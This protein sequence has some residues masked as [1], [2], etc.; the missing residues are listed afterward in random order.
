M[1]ATA[2]EPAA[3]QSAARAYS[4]T[5]RSEAII[6]VALMPVLVRTTTVRS[7]LEILPQASSSWYAAAACR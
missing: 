2:R 4:L 1:A 6:G 5:P 7:F 3:A